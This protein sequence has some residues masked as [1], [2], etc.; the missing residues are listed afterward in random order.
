MRERIGFERSPRTIRGFSQNPSASSNE[1]FPCTLEL[2]ASGNREW[3]E[4][5]SLKDQTPSLTMSKLSACIVRSN[6]PSASEPS[7]VSQRTAEPIAMSPP[8]SPPEPFETHSFPVFA[9][10]PG[11]NYTWAVR[12]EHVVW[13]ILYIW[14][15]ISPYHGSQDWVSAWMSLDTRATG[16]EGQDN[17][18]TVLQWIRS[19]QPFDRG[20]LAIDEERLAHLGSAI[21]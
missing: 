15:W 18:A 14:I 6:V 11:H 17:F 4:D 2:I 16:D 7:G 9:E 5:C 1:V 12:I 8:M 20:P 3:I 13:P 19:G 21:R 10:I